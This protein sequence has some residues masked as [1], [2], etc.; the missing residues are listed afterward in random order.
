MALH[1]YRVEIISPMFISGTDR[2]A[3]ELRA[4]SVRGQLRYW[5]RALLGAHTP[6]LRD[7]WDA[8]GRIFGSTGQG[9]QVIVRIFPQQ[10]QVAMTPML[11]HREG[12]G[13]VGR[14]AAIKSGGRATLQLV[15]RPGISLPS[16]ANYALMIWSLLGGMGKRSRRMFGAVQITPGEP[17]TT[18]YAK[19][20]SPDD[21]A[22][23]ITQ[24]LT[25]S[26]GN[27]SPA[28]QVP[29]FPT[30][31]PEHSWVVVGREG[32]DDPLDLNVS[33]FRNL[34]RNSRFRQ[35]E[36]TFGFARGGRRASPL[37]AQVRRIDGVYYPV[38]TALRSEP[39]RR[40]DWNILRDFMHDASQLFKGVT[41]WGG[42]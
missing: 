38:L 41:A 34:L 35:Y 37:H 21:L 42:W 26:I 18:W 4:P 7:V 40:I 3:P 12:S 6:R 23:T 27:P 5:L 9:S 15:T 10:F 30:L 33:L 31:H 24:L 36:D 13:N 19:P 25:N 22:Q 29:R 17:N 39:S 32:S 20:N 11:P 16:E 2:N 28:P 1:D 8:E 14:L